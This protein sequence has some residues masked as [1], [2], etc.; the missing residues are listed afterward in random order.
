VSKGNHQYEV[1]LYAS[2]FKGVWKSFLSKRKHNERGEQGEITS[3]TSDELKAIPT[4]PEIEAKNKAK[5]QMAS[6]PKVADVPVFTSSQQ[7]FYFIHDIILTKSTD[8]VKAYLF[9]IM[10]QKCYEENSTTSLFSWTQEWLN[11]LVDNHEAYKACYC[12]FP[13]VKYKSESMIHFF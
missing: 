7:L 8:E 12:P 4:L 1:R 13:S 5:S 11:K 2:E 10:S 9:N 6:L 3:Y